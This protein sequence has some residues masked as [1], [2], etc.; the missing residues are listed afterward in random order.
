M[1]LLLNLAN[2]KGI[3]FGKEDSQTLQNLYIK[4]FNSTTRKEKD[5]L[6]EME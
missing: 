4:V 6:A 1:G 2:M 5:I 3:A